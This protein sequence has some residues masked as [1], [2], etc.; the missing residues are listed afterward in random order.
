MRNTSGLSVTAASDGAF[1]SDSFL[2]P[3][4]SRD[5]TLST[6]SPRTET[7]LALPTSL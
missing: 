2:A 1:P 3:I 4:R 6:F 5:M 7:A